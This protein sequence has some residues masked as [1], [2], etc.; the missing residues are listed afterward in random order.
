[1]IL[2]LTDRRHIEAVEKL[3]QGSASFL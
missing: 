2:F 3:F 1:L